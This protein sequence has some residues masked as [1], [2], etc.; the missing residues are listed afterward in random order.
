[1]RILVVGGGGREHA[2]AWKLNLSP[3][4]HKVYCVP[5]NAGIAQVAKCLP[6]NVDDADGLIR[7]A[8][9]NEV[10]LVVVGPEAPLTA[11]LVDAFTAAGVPA[12]GPSK[13]AARLEGS[14]VFAKQLMEKYSIPTASSRVFTDAAA[15]LAYL[16]KKEA[17]VVVKADGLASGKGVIVAAKKEEAAA[18]VRLIMTDR[19]FGDAGNKVLIEEYLTGEEVSVMAFT[20]GETV[21]PMAP[22]QDHKAVY[23]LDTGPNTGGMGAYS[24]TPVLTPEM[25]SE[26]QT[27]I[28]Y[29]TV[30][31][32]RREGIA[33][34]GVL[35]A[36]LMMTATGPKVLEFN[37]RFGDP[38]CQVIL[39]R[40]KNDLPALMLATINGN[41]SEQELTW[42]RHHAAC[43]VMASGGYP[44]PYEKGFVISG[45]EEVAKMADVQVFHAGTALKD[46]KTVTA[47]GRVLAVTA[48]GASLPVALKKAYAACNTISFT[49]AHYRKDIGQKALRR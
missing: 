48:W 33:F 20:D 14:K 8:V 22:A 5:G 17:P 1:M 3:R 30:R 46:G 2:L 38:E 40:L 47:G 49:G 35:Y 27:R 10:D 44:G 28:L 12:F 11:G 16:E 18:A 41:L 21:L 6:L 23:D 34:R 26:V 7:L 31:A 43:V 9:Q 45:L 42:H 24:P 19:A 29:P 13:A 37:V 4:V 36:G 15:A 25:L 39:P 32:L